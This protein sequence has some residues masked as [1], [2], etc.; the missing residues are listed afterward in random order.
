MLNCFFIR[1]RIRRSERKRREKSD[2]CEHVKG[3]RYK[4][5]ISDIKKVRERKRQRESKG[6]EQESSR[7]VCMK[8][9]WNVG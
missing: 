8:V 2:R 9:K 7:D 6:M 3:S 4:E 5:K 1:P